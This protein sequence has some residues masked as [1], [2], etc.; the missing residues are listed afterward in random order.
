MKSRRIPMVGLNLLGCYQTKI[1]VEIMIKHQE[2]KLISSTAHR[3]FAEVSNDLK[4]LNKDLFD[5]NTKISAA[6]DFVQVLNIE[7]GKAKKFFYSN[8]VSFF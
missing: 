6:F 3:E 7:H 1:Q 4:L 2:I 5:L 8:C